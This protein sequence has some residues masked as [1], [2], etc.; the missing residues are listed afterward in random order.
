MP[1]LIFFSTLALTIT[2]LLG[3]TPFWWVFIPA[4][5]LAAFMVMAFIWAAIV[6]IVVAF[7][8]SNV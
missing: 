6:V 5:L 4:L 1:F 7:I 3:M 8:G 2:F